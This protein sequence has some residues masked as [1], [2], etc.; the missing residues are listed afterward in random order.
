MQD[1]LDELRQ[2]YSEYRKELDKA[3]RKQRPAD[4]LLGFGRSVKDDACHDRFDERI[5]HAVSVL[6]AGPLT[7]EEAGQA[8]RLLLLR[9]TDAEWH[10][11]A[12]WM[13]I[14]AERHSLP[15][16]AFLSPELAGSLQKEYAARYKP[17][18]RLPVQKQVLQALKERS[19]K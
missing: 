3:E 6:C 9:K 16:I 1:L 8:I 10:L 19:G 15:L 11:S 5:A 18:N 13:L 17:W 4:G 2:A 12:Q 14:A 7:S